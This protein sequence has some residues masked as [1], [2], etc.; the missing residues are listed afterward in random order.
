MA[1]FFGHAYQMLRHRDESWAAG[2]G[3][4]LGYVMVLL[5]WEDW[6]GKRCRARKALPSARLLFPMTSRPFRC[7][8]ANALS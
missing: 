5:T 3:Q 8:R 1:R 7:V 2:V 6:T 4:L